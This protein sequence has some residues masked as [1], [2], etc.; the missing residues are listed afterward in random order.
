MLHPASDSMTWG[1]LNGNSSE[2]DY[3]DITKKHFLHKT[4]A[5]KH[6]ENLLLFSHFAR[7]K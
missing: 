5:M 7:K 6:A 3:H 1:H 2:I 4:Y